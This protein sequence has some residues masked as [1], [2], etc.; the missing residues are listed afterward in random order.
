MSD[1]YTPLN[2]E[3]NNSFYI[4]LFTVI[5]KRL[6]PNKSFPIVGIS[7]NNIKSL[8]VFIDSSI[9]IKEVW[10]DYYKFRS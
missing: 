10:F 8:F 2:K 4:Y 6:T 5:N 9:I 7:L 1:L 3:E